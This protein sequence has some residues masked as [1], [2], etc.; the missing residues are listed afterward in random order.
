MIPDATEAD[1]ERDAEADYKYDPDTALMP[2]IRRAV[3]AEKESATLNAQFD[4]V[5]RLAQAL[6]KALAQRA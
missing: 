4:E 2:W 3:A 1:Y 6:I 5:W